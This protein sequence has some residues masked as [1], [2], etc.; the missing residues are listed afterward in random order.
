MAILDHVDNLRSLVARNAINWYFFIRNSNI[1]E[2]SI[3][4]MFTF[5]G[6]IM[7]SELELIIPKLIKKYADTNKFFELET[8]RLLFFVNNHI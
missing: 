6:K 8:D 7:D 4:D 5:C 3:A 1:N 2:I